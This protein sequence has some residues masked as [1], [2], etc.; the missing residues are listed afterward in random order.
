MHN[1]SSYLTTVDTVEGSHKSDNYP[2]PA[3]K[4][5]SKR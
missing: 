1:S 5:Q 3:K 2:S 4:E